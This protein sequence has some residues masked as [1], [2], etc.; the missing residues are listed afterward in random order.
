[1]ERLSVCKAFLSSDPIA[2]D[3]S[4][5]ACKPIFTELLMF[6]DL[7]DAVGLIS[8]KCL[9][10]AASVKAIVDAPELP[11]VLERALTRVR[12]TPFMNFEEACMLADE[13]EGVVHL[14]P[15]PGLSE[16]SNELVESAEAS[17]GT[18]PND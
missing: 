5:I 12:A 1:L 11:A 14:E 15:L 7:S 2:A 6:R 9:Q 18:G 16:T 13:I 3:D 17:S 8:L 4:F 10:V